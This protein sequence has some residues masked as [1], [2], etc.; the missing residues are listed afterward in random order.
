MQEFHLAQ[1]HTGFD[2]GI[3]IV[4]AQGYR[5]SLLVEETHNVEDRPADNFPV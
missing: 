5:P 1:R 4:I 2:P 3:S